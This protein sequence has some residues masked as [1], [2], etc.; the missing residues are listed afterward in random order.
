MLCRRSDQ[1]SLSAKQYLVGR[2]AIQCQCRVELAAGGGS[3]VSGSQA[4]PVVRFLGLSELRRSSVGPRV[5]QSSVR[6]SGPSWPIEPSR[7]VTSSGFASCFAGRSGRFGARVRSGLLQVE[8]QGLVRLGGCTV[9]A[10]KSDLLEGGVAVVSR[11][12]ARSVIRFLGFSELWK[13]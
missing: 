9:P 11:S 3:A 4:D 2:V 6:G 7:E 10:P 5:G 1:A 12:Q 8:K 13:S